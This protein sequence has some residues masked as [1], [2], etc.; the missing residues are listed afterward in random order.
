MYGKEVPVSDMARPMDLHLTDG[1][2]CL[3]HG[4]RSVERDSLG[5]CGI[6]LILGAGGPE[7]FGI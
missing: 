4:G 1:C 6:V 2:R 3:A 5:I 7:S